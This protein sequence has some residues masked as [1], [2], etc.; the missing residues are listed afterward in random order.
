MARTRDRLTSLPDGVLATCVAF[1]GYAG[2]PRFAAVSKHT[3]ALTKGPLCWRL[4]LED[5]Y[6]AAQSAERSMARLRTRASLRWGGGTRRARARRERAEAHLDAASD[7][8]GWEAAFRDLVG[9]RR[10]EA[11]SL[12]RRLSLLDHVVGCD[13]P[14]TCAVE[15]CGK[16]KLLIAHGASCDARPRACT[17]CDRLWQLLRQHSERCRSGPSCLVPACGQFKDLRRKAEFSP[18]LRY[19]IA[20]LERRAAAESAFASLRRHRTPADALRRLVERRGRR[21][22]L[23]RLR[24]AASRGAAL[25][26]MRG[27]L[28][29]HALKDSLARFA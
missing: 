7:G 14:A 8:A 15:R 1:L 10:S 25:R 24:A 29:K 22:A 17:M 19:V 9:E 27:V 23:R 21:D 13:A 3:N 26:A 28:V 18:A 12:R 16:L 20:R 6:A 11:R 2:V 4:F 5:E